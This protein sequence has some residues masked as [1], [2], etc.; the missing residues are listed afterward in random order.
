[1]AYPAAVQ[2]KSAPCGGVIFSNPNL[3]TPHL[4]RQKAKEP[5]DTGAMRII[6]LNKCD[7]P[8]HAELERAIADLFLQDAGERDSLAAINTRHRYALQQALDALGRARTSL[9]AAESPE[10]TD[11]HLREA[12]DALGTITGRIDTEDILSR[13]F[14]TFCLGK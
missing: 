5:A 9:E 10:L 13:V 1:M 11:V 4:P 12:L 6:L 14:S 2:E 8:E 3:P 7:L